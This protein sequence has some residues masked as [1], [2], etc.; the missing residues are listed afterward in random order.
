MRNVTHGSEV[1]YLLINVDDIILTA[2]SKDLLQRIIPS[3]HK[4][5]DM[6]DPWGLLISFGIAVT[7]DS[8]SMFFSQNKYALELLDSAHMASCN[9]TRTSVDIKP[10]PC[11]DGIHVSDPTL[12][13]SLKG[14]LQYLIFTHPRISYAVQ[15]ACLHMHDPREPRFAVVKRFLCYVVVTRDFGLQLYASSTVTCSIF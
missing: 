5:F 6:T 1:A 11:L 4:E 2:S 3:L 12:Y 15:H 10:N 13:R 8:T 7:L 14:D 9:L